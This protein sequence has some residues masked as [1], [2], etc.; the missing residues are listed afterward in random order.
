MTQD[1]RDLHDTTDDFRCI[2]DVDV[3]GTVAT[4]GS[5][6]GCDE[7]ADA[8]TVQ[9]GHTSK[10]DLG[11]AVGQ[12]DGEEQKSAEFIP[13]GQVDLTM[14]HQAAAAGRDAHFMGEVQGAAASPGFRGCTNNPADQHRG[15]RHLPTEGHPI[16]VQ[17][18]LDTVD[19][20]GRGMC[21]PL[22]SIH[23]RPVARCRP[24]D[25]RKLRNGVVL[26]AIGLIC[27]R[28]TQRFAQACSCRPDPRGHSI[29]DSGASAE[30]PFLPAHL[31]RIPI[32]RGRR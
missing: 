28:T 31:R 27:R 30:A 2:V 32:T 9:K 7:D 21:V 25:A 15:P 20:A 12:V 24:A 26:T 4:A 8:A 14:E 10:I 16:A 11:G 1:A 5:V 23:S 29:S 6:G 18:R 17:S 22:G 13:D 19:V 3:E